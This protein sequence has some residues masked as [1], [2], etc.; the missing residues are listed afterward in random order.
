MIIDNTTAFQRDVSLSFASNSKKTSI[1]HNERKTKEDALHLVNKDNHINPDL[2]DE[3]LILVSKP[4]KK[5]YSEVFGEAVEAYNKKQRRKDRRIK[6]F[7]SKV[8]HS[9]NL[10]PQKEFIVQVG[11]KDEPL[12][13][14]PK[15]NR[16]LQRKI[17]SSYFKKF[18]Q[19][20]PQLHT[21]SA[22]IHVDEEGAPHLHLCVVPEATGYKRG[23]S[24]QP[25]FSK[26]LGL[27]SVDDF[28]AFCEDNREL[29]LEAT[30]AV[31]GTDLKRRKVGTHAYR[32]PD[33]YR[34]LMAEAD[35]KKEEADEVLSDAQ[36]R[37]NEI[38]SQAETKAKTKS[39]VNAE[40][41]K[42]RETKMTQ[43]D[44]EVVAY[45]QRKLSQVDREVKT[46]K[47]KVADE[48]KT[49]KADEKNKADSDLKIYR[50]SVK[51]DIDSEKLDIDQKLA[52]ANSKMTEA[53]TKENELNTREQ[54]LGDRELTLNNRQ[55][56]LEETSQNLDDR[57]KKLDQR[58]K[59][60]DERETGL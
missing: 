44:K 18:E 45:K 56:T 38:L 24:K 48:V 34:Q 13:A 4:I 20:Y 46:Y 59:D 21:Y 15:R 55:E 26:A 36:E 31:L 30:N 19:T 22:A 51:A 54:G 3:N 52:D 17:L 14:D 11:K 32:M 33:E 5:V 10:D 37:A 53:L 42:Y 12:S 23:V 35:A 50:A 9:K 60:L 2:T 41:A 7:Y 6:D 57:E 1:K 29:L 39:E 25:S 43:V 28:K 40:L 47:S 58:E 27:K 8:W 16:E 49:Y